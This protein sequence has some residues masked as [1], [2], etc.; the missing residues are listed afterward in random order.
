MQIRRAAVVFI[1]A[2]ACAHQQAPRESVRKSVMVMGANHAG[3]QTVT[4]LGN[5]YTIDFEF[6]DR[7]RGPKT[8]TVMTLDARGIP[9]AETTTGNDYL[10][11]PV[12]ERLTSTGGALH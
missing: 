5:S 8:H 11:V 2:A 10:K 6:T 4:T 12:D 7:G 9:V 1:L 3:Q